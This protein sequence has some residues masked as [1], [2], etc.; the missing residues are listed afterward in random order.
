[1]RSRRG[2]KRLR[3][4]KEE[5]DEKSKRRKPQ[6]GCTRTATTGCTCCFSGMHPDA[7][8]ISFSAE[9]LINNITRYY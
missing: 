7:A 3:W 6:Q 4:G 8:Y 5:E 2:R 1:M 9:G